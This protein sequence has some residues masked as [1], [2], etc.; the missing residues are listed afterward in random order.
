MDDFLVF[1]QSKDIKKNHLMNKIDKMNNSKK[2]YPLKIE[3]ILFTLMLSSCAVTTKSE[4][5]NSIQPKDNLNDQ[6]SGLNSQKINIGTSLN[7]TRTG[8][9]RACI[10]AHNF[11]APHKKWQNHCLSKARDYIEEIYSFLNSDGSE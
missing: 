5:H 6:L 3:I 10:E 2:R 8:Y 11:H 4:N 9:V 1:R 7:L